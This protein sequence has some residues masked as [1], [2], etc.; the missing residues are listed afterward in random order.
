M[1]DEYGRDQT[2]R[3]VIYLT[4]AKGEERERLLASLQNIQN[5]NFC[6]KRKETYLHMACRAHNVEVINILLEQG[7]DPNARDINGFPPV[8]AALGM[9]HEKN[10]EILQIMLNAG[11]DILQENRG[12]TLKTHIERFGNGDL[13]RIIIRWMDWLRY[14]EENS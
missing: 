10:P 1:I 9:R 8:I 6:D 12:E 4:W 14:L 2:F 7:A 11:L 3:N 5:I 13:N